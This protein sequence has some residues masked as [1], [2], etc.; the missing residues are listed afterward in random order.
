MEGK[1]SKARGGRK[2][3]YYQVWG[4]FTM[5]AKSKGRYTRPDK[6]KQ[7]SLKPASVAIRREE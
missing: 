4:S 2:G 1:P 6:S 5:A 3:K 7:W